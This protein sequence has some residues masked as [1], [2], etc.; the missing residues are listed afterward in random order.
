MKRGAPNIRIREEYGTPE[1]DAAYQA[2]VSNVPTR[3][4][5]EIKAAQGTLEWAWL[6]YRQSGAWQNAISEATRR[7]RENIMKHVLESAGALPLSKITS[8]AI[9]DGVDRRAK[10]PSQAKNF[11]QTMSQFFA[12]LKRAKIVTENPCDGVELPKRLKTGGFKEWSIEEV[13]KY[14]ERWPIGTRERVMLDVYM[15]TGLRAATPPRSASST[16]AA[17]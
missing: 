7:Q 10:T 9:A 12:W 8:A 5:P 4:A 14:E 17:G 16:S 11:K 3:K 1:F 13:L 2:A 15:Y 6:L